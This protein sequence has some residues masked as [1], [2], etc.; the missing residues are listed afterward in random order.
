MRQSYR[1]D[2]PPKPQPYRT[3]V[4]DHLGLV[5]GMFEELGITEVIDKATQQEPAMRI[6]TAGHAVKA[7]VL[8]GLGFINQ[9]LYLVPHFFQNKPISRLI[10]PGIQASH[11]NDDTLGRA[12]DTLYAYG[13]TALYSLIAATAAKRLGLAPGFAHLDSTSFHVEG[14]YNSDEEPNEHVIHITRGYSRDQRPDLNQVMLDLIVEHQ[15]GIPVLMKPLSG[16]SSD[17]QD[18]GQLIADHV[19]QLQ[20]TY[21]STFLVADS[22]LYSAENLQKLAETR[23]KW[24]TRVPATLSEAQAVLAQAHPQTMTPLTE[25]YRYR[26]VPSSYGAVEQRWVLIHSEPRQPQ[27][28]RT[29]DKQWRKQSADEVKAFK[30][31]CRTAFA[32]EADAQQ[33]LARFAHDVQTTFLSDSTISPT[34]Q[35]G[36]RGRPGPGAQ[37]DQI[38]YHIAG[39]LASR[40]TDRQ[41]RVDQHSCFILATNELDE[42]QLPAP[43]VLAGYKG[44]ARAERG[45]RFLKDPQFL[46]SSLYLKKPERIM[47]LLMVMTVCLLVYAAL[48]YRIRTALKEHA[49]TFPDQKGKRIQ[50]PTA[51]WVFH[52]F[53]GIHVLFI[54]GQGLMVLNL[55]DEHQHLLQLLGKR[56]AWFYR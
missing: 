36:K 9:Q 21:G 50:N 8:N 31:L 5:A 32:C 4:L 53:V 2:I 51:R 54:P 15:A 45:F 35:Y 37:P 29:V 25:G 34:P 16:N 7:M 27:A 6:V 40:L 44:Q 17:A 23:T 43:E 49:A 30:T 42:A 47:A 18:F 56:Y 48:E 33:A 28:Q 14:R 1:P 10:A 11:L 3:L 39:A 55:T 41:A 13:V 24:I 52:Y 26:V 19:A 38:V 12:L 46:A 22:A 20:I